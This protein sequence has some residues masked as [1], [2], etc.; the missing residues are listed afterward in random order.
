M[1]GESEK[2]RQIG[3]KKAF[4]ADFLKILSKKHLFQQVVQASLSMRAVCEKATTREKK[5]SKF[6]PENS[7]ILRLLQFFDF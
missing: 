5:R 4:P 2:V 3:L 7:E 6:P 1:D